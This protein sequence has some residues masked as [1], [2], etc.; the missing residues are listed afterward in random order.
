MVSLTCDA[1]FTLPLHLQRLN[2]DTLV[3]DEASTGNASVW[4]AETFFTRPEKENKLCFRHKW[5][6][7]RRERK[8]EKK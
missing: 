2:V 3:A 1:V 4:L 7:T 6:K 5:L 8:H